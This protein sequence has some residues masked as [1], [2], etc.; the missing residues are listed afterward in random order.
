[1]NIALNISTIENQRV[2]ALFNKTPLYIEVK[3]INANTIEKTKISKSCNN[4]HAISTTNRPKYIKNRIIP[5][6]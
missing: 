4:P 1:M 6:I 2:E 5:I 3:E